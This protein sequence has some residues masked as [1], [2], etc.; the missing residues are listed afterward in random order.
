MNMRICDSTERL[1]NGAGFR[2]EEGDCRARHRG[3]E[4]F[5]RG[6][7]TVGTTSMITGLS[8]PTS[9]L[10]SGAVNA[11]GMIGKINVSVII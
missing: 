5:D 3:V 1:G 6:L 7:P 10:I 8:F 11:P 2:F 9:C 4:R